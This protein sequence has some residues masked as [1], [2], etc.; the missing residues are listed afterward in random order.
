MKKI[1]HLSILLIAL[2][3]VFSCKKDENADL[4]VGK[5]DLDSMRFELYENDV[6]SESESSTDEFDYL[7][8]TSSGKFY[9][10]DS[11]TPVEDAD[12]RRNGDILTLI[13]GVN[14]EQDLTIVTLTNTKLVVK[15]EDTYQQ[16]REVIT[17]YLTRRN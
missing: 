4:L 16:W 13:Y 7:E 6:L 11:G 1:G 5:W 10:Y 3:A 8:F 9:V 15:I 2:L 12:W 17:V 14:D